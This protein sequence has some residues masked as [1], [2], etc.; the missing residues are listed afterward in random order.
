MEMLVR[1]SSW[2]GR[3]VLVTGHTGFKGGWLA[4][5]LHA[6]GADVF[7]FSLPP[8]TRP[9]LF[10]QARLDELVE[11]IE[12]DVRDF[13]A[14][15]RAV[16]QFHP[17]VVFHLAA[18]PLVRYSYA[19][20]IETYDTNVMGTVHVLEAARRVDSVRAV[21]CVTT[22]K[23]YE[24]REWVWPYREVDP[25]GGH[26]P[27]SSSKA[28]AE[29]A[30]AAYR[31]S[32]PEKLKIASVRAGNVI[33]GGDWAADRLIPDVIRALIAGTPPLIRNPNS[34]RPWQHVLDA[35]S[36]YLLVAQQLLQGRDDVATAWNF[37]PSEDDV[38]PVGWIVQR[39][40]AMWGSDSGWQKAEGVQ[41]HEAMVLRLDSSQARSRLGWKS[42]MNL[43]QAL[44]SIVEWHSH[45][46]KGGDA[47]NT[48]M[49]QLTNYIERSEASMSEVQ[50]A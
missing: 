41:P 16:S 29:I 9:S 25:L 32:Y 42:Q 39:M 17:E 38:R 3:R 28:A 50:W 19:N 6:L 13:E 47:R 18:Q 46:N 36:G 49:L 35:L 11:H 27:Y 23:C 20:P 45:V 4:I 5:W 37:G 15:E 24:N 44:A 12:G 8:P 33:G 21:V 2:S 14:V 43:D 40:L 31:R 1:G 22:D 7:G 26:D 30:I 10:E 34:I 48:S